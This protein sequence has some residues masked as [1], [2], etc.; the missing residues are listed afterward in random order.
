M[1]QI[2]ILILFIVYSSNSIAQLLP[3]FRLSGSFYEQ[4]MVMGNSQNGTR[5]LKYVAYKKRLK[6]LQKSNYEKEIYHTKQVEINGFIHSM[7]SG[8][9]YELK[10]YTYFKDRPYTDFITDSIMAPIR[11]LNIPPRPPGSESGSQFM[12]RISSLLPDARENEIFRAI[13]SGNIP[14]FLRNTVTISDK[15]AD[16]EGNLHTVTY[17]TM[18]DYLSVGNDTDF[19][20]IPMNPYTAQ[21]LADMFGASFIT[22]KISDHIYKM[23]PIKVAPFN[24]TPVGNINESVI[25]FEEHNQQIEKQRE[26]LN[27][28]NGQLIAGIKKDIIISSQLINKPGKVIIYGWHKPG[29]KPIQPVYSGHI[30]WYV[31]YSHGVRFINNQ[32]LIDGNTAL[33]TDVLHDPVLF[34]LFSDEESPMK[35]TVYVKQ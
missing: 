31:D 23:A 20:R 14:E 13:A 24:Y 27:G 32:V 17:E 26:E 2:F 18:P 28:V 30:Y 11:I 15:F 3:G 35:Q 21:Q 4:Q 19:C 1:R 34:R 29:G 8:T 16:S 25:R 5:N 12:K 7:L 9:K 10:D 33:L 22:A 6:F